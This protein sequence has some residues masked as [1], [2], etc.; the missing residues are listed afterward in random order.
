MPTEIKRAPRQNVINLSTPMPVSNSPLRYKVTFGLP[1]G[2]YSSE[3]SERVTIVDVWWDL[4]LV[5]KD[6]P[7][8]VLT[9]MPRAK[10]MITNLSTNMSQELDL[11]GVITSDPKRVFNRNS[12]YPY[13]DQQTKTVWL[14]DSV[15]VYVHTRNPKGAFSGKPA[16]ASTSRVLQAPRK[17]TVT[18]LV[19]DES[20]GLVSCTVTRGDRSGLTEAIDVVSKLNVYNYTFN[21]ARNVRELTN[22]HSSSV[23][24]PESGTVSYDVTNR[25]QLEYDD[26]V[27]VVVDS[28]NR[29]VKGDSGTVTKELY[30]SWP[31]KPTVTSVSFSSIAQDGK[32]TASFRTN[33]NAQH[34]VTGVRLQKV[35][36]V[37]YESPSDIPGDEW[38]NVEVTDNGTCTALT[39]PV[40][41]V[42]P[43]TGKYSW[44][45]V[46]QWNQWESIFSRFSDPIR[47]TELERELPTAADDSIIILG[48]PLS[49]DDGNSAIVRVAWDRN[50]T[51]DATGTEITWSDNPN[52]WRSTEQPSQH[53]FT[54]SDGP[55]D[56]YRQSATVHVMGLEE[57]TKYWFRARRYFVDADG[58]E[59][60]GA[61]YPDEG[62][63][64]CVPTTS[65]SSVVLSV[66]NYVARGRSL[67][68]TWAYDSDSTQ[69]AWE[70][71]TGTPSGSG[72]TNEKVFER[73]DDALGS[74]TIDANRLA[75]LVGDSSSV[76]I[77]VR[78][79][80]GGDMV[81]SAFV[82]VEIADAP[83]FS[84]NVSDVTEQPVTIGMTCSSPSASVVM[85]VTAEGSAGDGP[86]GYQYQASGDTVWSD[87][88][89]PE[90][91]AS[92]GSYTATVSLPNG[93]RFMDFA[94][95]VVT[96]KAV[97]VRTGLES[98][99]ATDRF[100]VQWSRKAPQL[101]DGTTVTPHDVTEDGIR[102]RYAVLDLVAPSGA[103]ESDVCDVYRVTPDGETLIARGIA[104]SA[105][106]TDE[107]AP[108]GGSD[109]AYRVAIRTQDGDV[110]WRDYPYELGGSD[111][112]KRELRI[113]F[114]DDYIE[115][116]NGVGLS[117]AY[118][119]DF[120]SRRHLDGSEQG[121]WSSGTTRSGSATSVIVRVYDEAMD[122]ALRKLAR[123]NGPVMVRTSDG[124]AY[125]ANVDVSGLGI[126]KRTAGQT[127]SLD[128]TEVDATQYMATVEVSEEE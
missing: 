31:N 114:G 102:R 83:E 4:R 51:D 79:S 27:R 39:I 20:T 104:T 118:K 32:I 76:R 19:Q 9:P 26:Y 46:K 58:N 55:T 36:N 94:G 38:A 16:W 88:F 128:I 8:K 29:G 91:A 72:V 69:T 113:D 6:N 43:Q 100:E 68:V 107:W 64:T 1:A 22:V 61:Y 71:V 124:L 74:Y 80:T 106:V 66:P 45:R 86:T 78:V 70:L 67:D 103:S 85:V 5:A 116:D 65:P 13:T 3:N 99:V 14:L 121:Y 98:Q 109:M 54:W 34:P 62:E 2:A 23:V 81:Q 37:D 75:S 7:K 111:V 110:S 28:Y 35:V 87:A 50:G 40:S 93:S 15:I 120:E 117:D 59:T 12:Y 96:A 77:A 24:F 63:I 123:Y 48:N 97:D 90:W 112:F 10:Q 73:G 108:F 17:P 126:A 125:E 42:M 115:L 89:V 25:M 84:V 95:Y 11:A 53:R 47:L 49:G 101:G 30:V 105:T 60:Y 21:S 18:D 57:G 41:E 52:S 127:V 56:Q 33:E 44:I 119:K 82:D 122:R 92:G